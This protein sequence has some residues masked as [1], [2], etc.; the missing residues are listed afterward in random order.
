M[1]TE[2]ECI[3]YTPEEIVELVTRDA[4]S[5][6]PELKGATIDVDM[7]ENGIYLYKKIPTRRPP[8]GRKLPM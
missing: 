2:K 1:P 6:Y 5:R 3:H 7:S 8:P 4:E